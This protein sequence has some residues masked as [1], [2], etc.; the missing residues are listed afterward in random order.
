MQPGATTCGQP[1]SRGGV[2][3]R[4]PARQVLLGLD[5]RVA[6]VLVPREPAGLLRLLVHGLVPVEVDVGADEVG[7]EA[8]EGRV[9]G[10]A[11]SSGERVTRW[12]VKV[13]APASAIEMRALLR[14]AR[15]ASIS[16]S[17][18]SISATDARASSRVEQVGDDDEAG[19][20]NCA[21]CSA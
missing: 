9:L 5:E 15:N 3:E 11:A 6:V 4:D 21:T 20:S 2:G 8:D 10:D 18:P 14:V 1:L 16:P 19:A 12:V 13:M 17:N 7:A